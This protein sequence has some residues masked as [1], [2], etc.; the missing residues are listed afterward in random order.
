MEHEELSGETDLLCRDDEL[1]PGHSEL[2]E[3][4]EREL[5][6]VEV[7]E[8]IKEEIKA[9]VAEHSEDAI[10]LYLRELQKTKLLSAYE[11]KELAARIDLGDKA[12]RDRMIVSNLRLVVKIAKGH[13]NRGL[14]FL[15]LIEEGNL[16]LIKAVERFE[17]SRGF[18]FSTYAT[19]WIRQSIDRALTNHSRTIRLPAHISESITRMKGT[20]R[21]LVAQLNREPTLGEVADTLG[22]EVAY[23]RK[24][25]GLLKKTYSLEQ[26]M[27]ESNYLLSETI[28]DVSAVSAETRFEDLHTYE[29]V[30]KWLETLSDEEK[31][32]ITLRFGLNDKDQQTLG[33]IGKTFGVTRER[34]RQIEKKAL[35]KIR[36][37]MEEAPGQT[38]PRLLKEGVKKPRCYTE[39][40]RTEVVRLMRE[41]GL[42]QE[43]GAK[44][45]DIPKRTLGQWLKVQDFEG[46]ADA[47]LSRQAF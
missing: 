45:F 15:D 37:S 33:S 43:A 30:S 26:P 20:T 6:E 46:S 5:D 2:E 11:E 13:L 23:V 42:S 38:P 32:V 47:V 40:Y 24:L 19:W 41:R 25:S 44:K 34:I 27:G 7:E 14:P 16:G 21:K 4:A 31:T 1:P 17:V 9:T 10:R 18:R 29:Q 39:E 36:N 22:V 3:I 8:E 28:E 12:A 35:E